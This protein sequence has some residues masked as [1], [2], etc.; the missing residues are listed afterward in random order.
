[1]Y[2]LVDTS[3]NEIHMVAE[4]HY[5]DLYDPGLVYVASQE[6]K[7]SPIWSIFLP[8]EIP[9]QGILGTHF[10]N[11]IQLLLAISGGK[12]HLMNKLVWSKFVP[13]K[14][15][16]WFRLRPR[17]IMKAAIPL[18]CLCSSCSGCRSLAND[19]RQVGQDVSFS[20]QD[21]RQE[22]HH[23]KER[24]G[25]TL[26]SAHSYNNLTSTLYLQALWY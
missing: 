16:K 9:Q 1:M 13:S 25:K 18:G 11:L 4:S 19:W 2:R 7:W 14:W 3:H 10:F 5:V 23:K 26:R 24:H 12:W 6:K 20:N 21:L 15:K 22:L 8:D 17:P